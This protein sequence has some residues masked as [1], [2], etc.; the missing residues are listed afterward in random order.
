MS[1]LIKNEGSTEFR[2]NGD[3]V[4]DEYAEYYEWYGY[5]YICPSIVHKALKSAAGSDVIVWLSSN[6]GDVI[7]GSEIYTAFKEY[8]ANVYIKIDGIAASAASFIAMGADHVGI[9]PTA[10]IMIHNPMTYAEGNI[11]EM[12]AA[13]RMLASAKEA[14]INAYEI[15]TGLS[16]DELSLMMDKEEFIEAHRAVEL[17]FADEVLFEEKVLLQTVASAS[18]LS[19]TPQMQ[20]AYRKIQAR[21]REEPTPSEDENNINARHAEIR[22]E[23]EWLI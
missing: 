3:V 9:S 12:D 6:G 8:Q 10:Q 2:L 15:K 5:P 18:N 23:L 19:V 4:S 11:Y 16:R 22:R 17:G 20:A 13:G 1:M 21:A 7:S 14:I